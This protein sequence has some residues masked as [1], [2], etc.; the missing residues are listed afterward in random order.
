MTTLRT[1]HKW[2]Y[3]IHLVFAVAIVAILLGFKP[4]QWLKAD[5]VTGKIDVYK[6]DDTVQTKL[7]PS[8]WTQYELS[9]VLRSVK[10][11]KV[12]SY[13]QLPPRYLLF[14]FERTV[15]LD[16]SPVPFAFKQMIVTLPDSTW[17]K[18]QM[19]L[20]NPQGQWLEYD[21]SHPL[22]M[23]LRDYR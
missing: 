11:M 9:K 19:L 3:R 17:Q 18:P 1:L 2:D 8:Q 5:V 16:D 15:V 20:K 21:M 14:N 6:F 13:R 12:S 22:T 4:D 23:L 7:Q 10:T